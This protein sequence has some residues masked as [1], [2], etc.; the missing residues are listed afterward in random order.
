MTKTTVNL[1]TTVL[2]VA[3]ALLILAG[4]IFHLVAS[5]PA[6]FFGIACFV[7]AGAVKGLVPGEE[8]GEA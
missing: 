5:N 8:K 3:G 2:G 6:L 4:P 7:V 1:L